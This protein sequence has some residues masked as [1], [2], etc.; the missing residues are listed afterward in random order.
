MKRILYLFLICSFGITYGQRSSLDSLKNAANNLKVQ[1]K[2]FGRDTNLV[3]TLGEIGRINVDIN[4]DSAYMYIDSTLKILKRINWEKGWGH[5]YRARGNYEMELGANAEASEF[6]FKALKIF[7]KYRDYHKSAHVLMTI[8]INLAYAKNYK[9]S[10]KYHQKSI[11]L[12]QK[13]NFPAGILSNYNNIGNTF[14]IAKDYKEAI[15]YFILYQKQL[16]TTPVPN[17]LDRTCINAIN[18]S[19]SY[20]GL[21]NETQGKK[22]ENIALATADELKGVYEHY[23]LYEELATCFYDQKNLDKTIEYVNLAFPY[24]NE[25]KSY[26]KISTLNGLL[27]K[28]YKSMG[29]DKLALIYYEKHVMMEDSLDR[30]KSNEKTNEIRLRYDTERQQNEIN[31]LKLENIEQEQQQRIWLFGTVLLVTSLIAIGIVWNN[32]NLR[33]KNEELNQ[34][35]KEIS[36]ALHKGQTLERKRVAAEL[37]DSLGGTIAAMRLQIMGMDKSKFSESELNNYHEILLMIQESYKQVRDLSH[38]LMPEILEKEGL[39][40]ALSKLVDKMNYSGLFEFEFIKDSSDNERLSPQQDLELY[41]ICLE[42]INNIIK[43]SKASKVVIHY[44]K[45]EDEIQLSIFDN[46]KGFDK[47]QTESG[48]GLFSVSNRIKSLGGKWDINS[49]IGKGT[50]ITIQIP[51]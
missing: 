1:A 10:I 41:S 22:Y 12:Y 42:L 25:L 33:K 4:S 18:L 44:Q 28:A 26:E 20:Y 36:E 37:H 29:N 43:H 38:N 46:G 16:D 50:T 14:L 47:N 11:E 49:D 21:Q 45:D 35:N 48:M 3:K 24:A 27:Y 8:G 51:V 32:Y 23:I 31:S 6:L 13:I 15:K 7:E 40:V 30:I 34:K 9:E 2:S 39:V 5:Y 17:K 19:I